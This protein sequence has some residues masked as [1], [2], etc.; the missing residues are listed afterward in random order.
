MQIDLL[1]V[2]LCLEKTARFIQ[3]RQSHIRSELR[4]HTK[5][6]KNHNQKQNDLDVAT[7][8]EC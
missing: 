7:Q 1:S 3:S 5:Q 4:K 2:E 6:K 8:K